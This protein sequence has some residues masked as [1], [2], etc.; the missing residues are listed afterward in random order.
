MP[1]F[2]RPLRE[3][4]IPNAKS[5]KVPFAGFVSGYAFR[6]IATYIHH[7]KLRGEWAELHFILRAIELGLIL[8]KPTETTPP[9]TS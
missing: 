4:G 7:P 1:H 9:T 8:S 3:V 5:E 6:H 2:S